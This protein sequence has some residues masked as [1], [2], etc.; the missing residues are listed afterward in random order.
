M[1]RLLDI[2]DIELALQGP[3]LS[4]R[5]PGYASLLNREL[6]FGDQA[7][8]IS[9]LNPAQSANQYWR[10]LSTQKSSVNLPG[11]RHQ[12][13]LVWHH[14]QSFDRAQLQETA[15]IAVPTHYAKDQISLLSGVLKS[16][17][18]SSGLVCKR[19]LL[20]ACLYPD[21]RYQID[22]QLHQLVVTE[23]EKHGD[24]IFCGES[25]EYPGLG[26]LGCS[27]A[28]LKGIQ[29]RFIEK[30]RFD[31][32]HHAVTE[33]QLFNQI[34]ENL[35]PQQ[36]RRMEFKVDFDGQQNSI[37]L[38]E[39]QLQS[40]AE[41][42]LHRL[43]QAL[44]D[45]LFVAD[46]ILG[47]LPIDCRPAIFLEPGEIFQALG[48]ILAGA[49]SA[50][51]FSE[52]TAVAP[53]VTASEQGTNHPS[54]NT[55]IADENLPP[56]SLTVPVHSPLTS[57]IAVEG[58]IQRDTVTHILANGVAF[59]VAAAVIVAANNRIELALESSLAPNQEVLGRFESSS[60]QSYLR[61]EKLLNHNGNAFQGI[62]ELKVKDLISQEDLAGT[63]LA[64]QVLP[65]RDSG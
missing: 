9:R 36:W 37:E 28:L 53:Q 65:P 47:N 52:L 6:V 7:R 1:Y 46:H 44:P 3:D 27:D 30:T 12:A 22:F 59:P 64:I 40:A 38:S 33:Q 10:D 16:L 51:D 62:T 8:A 63:L 11:V 35:L 57:G 61:A 31:P 24:E 42:Y 26:L 14:L 45:E 5:S 48:Q 17:N 43:S 23:V 58:D 2:S 55:R 25:V 56:E 13:D 39:Q 20:M 18:V 60:S 54:E 49:G 19:A 4:V 15:L 34:M 50:E 41:V 32:L 21:V 29:A